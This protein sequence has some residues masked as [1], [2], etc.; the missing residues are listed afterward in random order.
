MTTKERILHSV[1]FEIFALVIIMA[2]ASLFT[3][4]NPAAVGGMG[5][6]MSLIAMAWNYIY[7]LGFDKVFGN[8]RLSR[9]MG[10]RIAHGIGF[11]FGLIFATIPLLMWVLQKDFWTVLILD[12]GI[13]LFFLVYSI[14]YNLAYDHIKAKWFNKMVAA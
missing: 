7:N 9:K 6:V 8:D 3:N 2:G 12:I 11:E 14:L 4:H 1:L 5:L 10:T 13:V